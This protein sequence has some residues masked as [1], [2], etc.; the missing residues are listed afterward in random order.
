M[1]KIL[2]IPILLFFFNTSQAQIDVKLNPLGILFSSPDL[3]VEYILNENFGIEATLG[4]DF[5]NVAGS[6]LLDPE[7][8]IKKN[9]YKLRISGKY[10]FKPSN[11]GD[12]FYAGAYLGPRATGFS[13]NES[14]WGYDPGYKTSAFTVGILFGFKW[15][16]DNGLIFE[17]GAGG[18]RAFAQKTTFNEPD[19]NT[20]TDIGFGVDFVGTL[21]IGYRF[22]S[23][24][25][26]SSKKTR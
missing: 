13:G 18:G 19:L 8:Q 26:G 2:F 6:G 21:A 22:G 10:Y 5:G 12:R 16:A 17:I 20:F 25:G 4:A 23:G 11:G 14:F 1:K 3:S 15:A 24:D 9:G 7:A